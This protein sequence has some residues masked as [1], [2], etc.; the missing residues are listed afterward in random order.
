MR[1]WGTWFVIFGVGSFILPLFGLQFKILSAF[2][3]S[4]PFVAGG[5]A[6]AG[7]ALLVLSFR[8]SA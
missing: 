7:I 8:K 4:L 1:Q 2:G 5:L 6:L 3:D